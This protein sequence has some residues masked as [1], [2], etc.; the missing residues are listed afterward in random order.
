MHFFLGALSV[1]NTYHD[2]SRT[3]IHANL[4]DQCQRHPI[5]WFQGGASFV[6]HLCYYFCLALLCFHVRLFVD[7]LWTPAGKGLTS[8]PSFG[9]SNCGV[10]FPVG[11]LG[12]V[13][14]LIVCIDS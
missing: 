11:I 5:T 1:R 6:D 3:H 8:W 7:A 14:C 2:V 12:Q 10:H 13:L 4:A 9:M